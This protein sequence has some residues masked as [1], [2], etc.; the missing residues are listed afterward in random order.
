MRLLWQLMLI[1][2]HASR[3]SNTVTLCSFPRPAAQRKPRGQAACL[4]SMTSAARLAAA[5]GAVVGAFV[6]DASGAPLE[7]GA[8]PTMTMVNRALTMPGGGIWDV[9]PGQIT[10]DSEM[11]LCLLRGLE[12]GAPP[13]L[14]EEPIAEAY[15]AWYKSEPFDI[16]ARRPHCYHTDARISVTEPGL[17]SGALM[18]HVVLQRWRLCCRQHMQDSVFSCSWGGA[19]RLRRGCGDAG[20]CGAGQLPCT[21]VAMLVY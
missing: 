20:G 4:A 11:A 6:G 9:G 3:L 15:A 1:R 19:P 5:Q 16:G 13:S 17:P 10:D 14:P 18:R 21:F 8:N 7:F 2:Q 12:Q